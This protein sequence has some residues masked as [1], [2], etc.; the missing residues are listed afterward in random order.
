VSITKIWAEYHSAFHLHSK[1]S[2]TAGIRRRFVVP[3]ALAAAGGLNGLKH[4]TDDAP[5]GLAPLLE[6]FI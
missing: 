1:G 6:R 4:A 3:S 2:P 5:P